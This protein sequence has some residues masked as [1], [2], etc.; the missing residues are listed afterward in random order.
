MTLHAFVDESQRRG[1]YLLCI[2]LVAPD[3]LADARSAMRSLLESGQ[4]S[5]HF[6]HESDRRRRRVLAA[7][8]G[9]ELEY[10]I[11]SGTGPDI[12]VRPR[13]LTTAVQHLP[14]AGA[15]RLVI[16]S[17]AHRDA[18]DR[19][20]LSSLRAA[21]LTYEHLLAHEEPLLWVPDAVAWA[22]GRGGDWRRRVQPV[23]V[24]DIG[25]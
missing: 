4:R 12:A 2:V 7:I 1:T 19:H 8:A 25:P 15:R 9:L 20:T 24:L 3:R 17:R 21:Q 11:V 10:W 13:L 18:A 6:T 5:I 22:H 14:A 23:R 16:E